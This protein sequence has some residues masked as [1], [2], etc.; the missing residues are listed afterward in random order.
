MSADL[1]VTLLKEHLL[2][3][4]VHLD[5]DVIS[6]TTDGCSVMKKE[7]KAVNVYHQKC[8]AHSI[9]LAILDVLYKDTKGGE[10]DEDMPQNNDEDGDDDED[11]DEKDENG[12]F[13]IIVSS[14]P[15]KRE[16]IVYEHV[17]NK[18]RKVAKLFRKSPTKQAVLKKYVEEDF[19]KELK[20]ITDCK[21]RWSS[22]AD[23]LERF[24]KI[25]ICVRKALIDVGSGIDF[26]ESEYTTLELFPIY[27]V[28]LK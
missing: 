19:H 5:S 2:K 17:I 13:E 18:V 26:T 1:C 16:D 4:G 21:T 12:S 7:G 28:L 10:I 14:K 15:P 20:L 23:M 3:F 11:N 22:L 6:L 24:L 8:L 9:Q 25:K 27:L